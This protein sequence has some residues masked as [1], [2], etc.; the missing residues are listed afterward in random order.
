MFKQLREYHN[1]HNTRMNIDEKL[2][3]MKP[4]DTPLLVLGYIILGMFL[5]IPLTATAT[6]NE[7]QIDQKGDEVIIGIGQEGTDNSVD[8]DLG[9]TISEYNILKIHQDGFNNDV[10]FSTDGD[11]NEISILQQGNNNDVSW[12]DAWGS[13]YSYG[14]D[15][16][17]NNN[18]LKIQQ[19]CSFSTCNANDVQFHIQ[20][21]NNDVLFGQ[22][23]YLS[24]TDDTTF[25][26]DNYEPGGNFLRL[27]IHGDNNDFSGSQKMD[28]S[29]TNHSMTVNLYSN[30]NDVFAQQ[31]ANGNKTLNLTTYN[32]SNIVDIEQKSTGAH[33]ATITLSGTYA[34]TLD[35]LQQGSTAQS[36]SLTQSCATLGGCSISVIQE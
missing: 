5:L 13:L 31:W 35:L 21:N 16:D 32:D 26:Y 2:N 15:L 24:S 23:Y 34:T 36:Y 20:G 30:S 10:F 8:I 3:N 7:V 28:S 22:G 4:K 18:T 11:N 6:D 1:K 17:G 14:G 19:R 33:S 25:D 9:I 27:D 29:S 12:T